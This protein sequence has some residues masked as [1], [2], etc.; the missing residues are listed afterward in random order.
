MNKSLC[1]LIQSSSCIMKSDTNLMINTQPPQWHYREVAN[2]EFK[3]AKHLDHS[4]MKIF[5]N[6]KSL[7]DNIFSVSVEE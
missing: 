6:L 1:W 4:P 2:G 5:K 3:Q 7:R